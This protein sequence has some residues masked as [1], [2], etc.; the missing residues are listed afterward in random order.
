MRKTFI[1]ASI[2]ALSAPVSFAQS[3]EE[4]VEMVNQ[5]R[6]Q[7][8]VCGGKRYAAAPPFR[9]NAALQRAA[10]KHADD[11]ATKGYFSHHSRDG[12]SPSQRIQAEGYAFWA[13]AENVAKGH[14]HAQSAINSW[15]KSAGHCAN[16]MNPEY[17][18]MGMAQNG[19]LW[20]Q[21]F[22]KPR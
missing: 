22:G 2:L 16:I 18:E 21:T 19:T 14:R 12:R 15:L 3:A 5:V 7:A 4:M 20:V 13:A 11:M 9:L 6:S 17:T 10:Q 1:L 8:R